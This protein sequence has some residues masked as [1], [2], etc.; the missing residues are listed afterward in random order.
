M[1]DFTTPQE[2]FWA[3]EFGDTYTDRNDGPRWIASNLSLFS[4]I[5]TRTS[6]VGSVLELGANRGLNLQALNQLLPEA[7]FSAVEI[8]EKAVQELRKFEWLEVQH[9]SILDFKPVTKSELVFIKGVMIHLNPEVLPQ[10]Y[11]LMQDASAR[12]ICIIEYYNPSPVTVPYRGHTDRLF[13]RDFAGEMMR[14]HPGLKL[15]DYGF[16]YHGDLNFPQD[17]LTWFLLEK[18]NA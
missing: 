14:A 15:V 10:V 9:A 11:Q 12:Y 16:V 13:K 7:A 6:R 5:L 4:R 2:S 1:S 8:N 17:D 3:G 18:T